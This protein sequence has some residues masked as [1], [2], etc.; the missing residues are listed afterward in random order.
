MAQGLARQQSSSSRPP[1][2]QNI[3]PVHTVAVPTLV[4]VGRQRSRRQAQSA[5]A[6]STLKRGRAGRPSEQWSYAV[7][8]LVNPGRS[9]ACEACSSTRPVE[10]RGRAGRPSEQWSCAVY[11]LVNPG[12]SHACEACSSTCP[13]EVVDAAADDDLDLDLGVLASASFL[14]LRKCSQKRGRVASP[15]AVEVR[16]DE[17][18]G[19]K[20]GEDKAAEKKLKKVCRI[21]H[22]QA[23]ENL[24]STMLDLDIIVRFLPHAAVGKRVERGDVVQVTGARF[25]S[26]EQLQPVFPH[27]G[28]NN[29]CFHYVP[30]LF[31]RTI[32]SADVAIAAVP[33]RRSSSRFLCLGQPPSELQT[34]Q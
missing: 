17:G 26:K 14:P 20:G 7:C 30:L 33:R 24:R 13:V 32:P 3:T 29:P 31:D 12:C 19:T 1:P 11:T 8:T 27:P 15:G 5:A 6:A 9:R 16:P 34:A 23:R 28:N 25:E 22:A 4:T 21:S 10:K 18:D 2:R